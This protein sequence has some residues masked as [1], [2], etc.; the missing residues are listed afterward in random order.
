MSSTD[1]EGL[2]VAAARRILDAGGHGTLARILG[3]ATLDLLPGS[4]TWQ[5]DQRAVTAQRVALVVTPE[6]FVVLRGES[7]AFDTVKSAIAAVI[8]TPTTRLAGLTLVVALD[9]SITGATVTK[10]RT[11]GSVYRSAATASG[12]TAEPA[13]V[14]ATAMAL[15]RAYGDAASERLLAGAELARADLASSSGILLVRWIVALAPVDLV[16]AERSQGI[17]D[18]IVRYVTHAAT[19]ATERVA[20]VEL[21]AREMGD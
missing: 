18:H 5:I 21:R 3:S 15:A 6:D 12:P 8:D 7:G 20:E 11:W 19:R 17:G 9:T 13:R 10:G 1:P 4:E 14:L 16:A 2:V